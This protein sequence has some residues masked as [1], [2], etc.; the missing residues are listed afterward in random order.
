MIKTFLRG[1]GVCALAFSLQAFGLDLRPDHPN[2]YV[3]KRGDTLWDIS[4]KFLQKPWHWPELWQ[5]NPQIA[6]PH[7]IYPGDELTLVYVDGQPRLRI[8]RGA[9][10]GTVK[11]SPKVRVTALESP[12]P[13]IPL[14]AI[15]S[16]LVGNRV[17]SPEEAKSAPYVLAGDEKHIIM[18]VGDLI[19]ARGDWANPTKVYGVYR[20]GVDF[21]DPETKEY[22]GFGV[23]DLG[24]ARFEDAEAGVARMRLLTTTQDV[25]TN[26]RLL[27]SEERKLDSTFYPRSPEQQIKGH[28][29][30]A[31]SGVRNASQYDVIVINRGERERLRV[32]DV[33]AIKGL[34]ETVKDGL[35]GDLVK[36]PNERRGTVILFRTFEKVS[37]GL[38]LRA[39]SPIRVG[40]LVE[41]PD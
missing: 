37:Y 38:I 30:H 29:I 40:D 20:E 3:V 34:G 10:A 22:L 28:I 33:L 32:G 25:R 1:I 5:A 13:A 26:D 41:N 23:V 9:A 12:I 21:V 4:G 17:I 19:Y 27:Q 16:F 15:S 35:R 7:L 2:T 24:S 14:D 11:L 6:N 31:F 36:L 18:G 39:L 8:G